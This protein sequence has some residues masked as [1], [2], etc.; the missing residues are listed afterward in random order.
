MFGLT[1]PWAK[2]AGLVAIVVVGVVLYQVYDS[3]S[4]KI[5][6]LSTANGELAAARDNL[7]AVNSN[8]NQQIVTMV[9]DQEDRA[10]ITTQIAVEKDVLA[11]NLG[12]V[13]DDLQKAIVAR[14]E[15]LKSAGGQQC[16][17]PSPSKPIEV[18]ITWKA[19]CSVS[20][21]P[22]CMAGSK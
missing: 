10:K 9:K 15:A 21:D 19:Y 7:L 2:I 6:N 14:D 16:F 5:A 20:K 12:T 4:T 11:I 18:D 1:I 13:N 17:D 22:K 3:Q 8:L